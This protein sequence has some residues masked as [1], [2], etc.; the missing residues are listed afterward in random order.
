MLCQTF[1]S[2]YVQNTMVLNGHLV[3]LGAFDDIRTYGQREEKIDVAFT[4]N[5]PVDHY[6]LTNVKSIDCAFSFGRRQKIPQAASDDDYHPTIFSAS[7][8]LVREIDGEEKFENISVK[9]S[10]GANNTNVG[11][12]II[13][14]CNLQEVDAITK[15][16][17][18][19]EIVGVESDGL[20]PTVLHLRYN[21]SKKIS[22][23]LIS[24]ISGVKRRGVPFEGKDESSTKIPTA[25]FVRLKEI[26]SEERNAL[27]DAATIPDELKDMVEKSL[28]GAGHIKRVIVDANFGIDTNVV[29][30]LIDEDTVTLADWNL[31]LNGLEPNRRNALTNFI[32]KWRL[33][34]HAAWVDGIE[35][36]IEHAQIPIRSLHALANYLT[37]YFTRAIKYLGP[38]RNEPQAVYTSV[39]HIDP[40][41]VGLKGE[42]T[43]A[44]LH[45]NKHKWIEYASP[46]GGENRDFSFA[47]KSGFLHVACKEWLSYLGVIVEY[48]TTDKGKLGYE[49]QV[50]TTRDD[51]W[52]DLTHVGVGV[53]QILPIVLMFLLSEPGDLLIFEQPELHLHPKIQSRLCDFFFAMSASGR[54]C[55][56][57]T[58]SEYLINRLRLRIAQ[59]QDLRLQKLASVFFIQKEN[60]LSNF[61]NIE[62]NQYGAIPEWPEDFFDQTDRE[63]ENILIEATN[64]RRIEKKRNS[65]ATGFT[66]L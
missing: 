48:Q 46:K 14:Q 23:H 30:P 42:F 28:I 10:G 1:S 44:A 63:V 26:I 8:T 50:K 9:Q 60:S 29:D 15:D 4:I 61:K 56:I 34:L 52:Q 37:L 33:A 49:L 18:D 21:H 5:S 35:M 17:P 58:H 27:M 62:I 32:D 64:K 20:I 11:F 36:Q 55:L 65:D 2:R 6:G 43:A 40:N 24:Q 47:M 54:Q 59:S 3:R 45:I 38:L 57:E 12:Y 53:S 7:I 13:E 51:C 41:H 22:A 66:Q 19:C 25:F 31:F 16:Y 39:G